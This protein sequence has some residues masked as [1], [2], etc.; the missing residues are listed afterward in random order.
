M[1]EEAWLITVF[2][3][4][5]T[6]VKEVIVK[7]YDFVNDLSEVEDLH[8]IMR[9]RLEDDVVISFRTRCKEDEKKIVKSK[10]QFKLNELL[11]KDL[12]IVDPTQEDD[13][14]KY[15]AWPWEDTI[16]KRGTEKFK[17]FTHFLREMS[18]L[19]IDMIKQ[20]YFSSHER[21]ELAHV[22][23][24]MLGCTEY[25]TLSKESARVGYYDRIEDRYRAYL[26]KEF[27]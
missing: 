21:T 27:K 12:Y 25:F 10:I 20:D 11:S 1:S 22:M 2:K 6:K 18:K 17:K 15:A 16:K 5:A 13:L 7:F 8:F 4:K 26:Q 14:F 24:W 3:C 19:V 9:D 23:S